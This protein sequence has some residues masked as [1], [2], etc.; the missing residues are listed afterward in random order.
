MTPGSTTTLHRRQLFRSL[1]STA[2][3]ILLGGSPRAFAWA[4]DP[5]FSNLPA[6]LSPMLAAL[7]S[8]VLFAG[9]A[10]TAFRDPAAVYIDGHFYLFYT[11]V[12]TE[13]DGIAYSRVAFSQSPDLLRW[14]PPQPITQEDKTLEF[15]SP[16]DIVRCNG[17][18]VLCLQTYPRPHREMFGDK[19]SR[20]WTMTSQDLEHWGGLSL[21][22][23]KGPQLDRE[24]MGRMIDPFLLQDKDDPGKWWCFFK[25]NGV[26]LSWS[27]DL[28]N[29]TYF[30]KIQ[31]GEN[32]C[33]VVDGNEYVLFHSP[34]NGIGIMRSAN[35]TDWR[36]AGLLTLGQA[37]WPWAAGR[38]TAGFVL[39]LR[40]EPA[41]GKALMF[42]H[43]SAYPEKDPRG[44]FDTLASI[45]IAWSDDLKSWSWPGAGAIKG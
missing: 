18:W 7:P 43:G 4:A 11:Y 24:R 21:L 9:D 39:D 31:A 3:G 35:L 25:Q 19:T 26:S 38:I 10:T 27:R 20:I 34:P 23:V 14:S 12:K 30:G 6:P 36:N 16:G 17:Q 5:G 32:P 28:T 37:S 13:P 29:W 2:C 45:G 44:G 42:F 1:A 33:V 8:P 15:G 40:H 22:R 41:V